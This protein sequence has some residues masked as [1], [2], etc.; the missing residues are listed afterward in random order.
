MATLLVD[1]PL[2][3]VT[4]DFN[5][6]GIIANDIV[7]EGAMVG[8]NASGYGRPLVAGDVFLGHSLLNVDNEDGLAGAKEIRLRT[9][10][11][12][13]IVT[14]AGLLITDV[15]KE[16][17]ASDDA[18]YSLSSTGNSRVGVVIRYDS[19]NRAVVEFQTNEPYAESLDGEITYAD[20]EPGCSYQGLYEQTEA[21]NYPIGA[22]RETRQDG[23]MFYYSRARNIISTTKF[24]LKF[25]GRI[26][27]GIATNLYQSQNAGDKTLTIVGAGFSANDFR[28]GYVII[29]GAAG[30]Q[31][32]RILSSTAT[33]GGNVTLTLDHG[34][35]VDVTNA[36]YTEVLQNPYGNLRLMAGP[37][38]GM[39]GNPFTSVAGMPNVMT[40]QNNRHLWIKTWGPM[41][42][43]PHGDS[44]Q[45]AGITGGERKL[46][47]DAE[48]SICIEDDVAHGPGVDGD[49][50]QL[51][52][53]IIDRS[54]SGVS[55]PPL[56]QL[57]I[58]R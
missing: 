33:N 7:F 15:L 4:G 8:D 47:F 2:T 17:Y 40:T 38:G 56:I 49:E 54:A 3:I 36:D 52:G 26:G 51:A 25:Y 27:D 57:T 58:N 16:V 1:S 12:R 45:N 23:S 31:F 6:I 42:T 11:Y 18:T 24:G 20:I 21:Q 41:W 55:G 22:R 30:Q 10:R 44:L 29:H 35:E 5:S 50:H 9:G 43:N 13:G 39:A 32:R 34:L 48:G 14:I 46:V 37:S 53:H 19:A 28:G